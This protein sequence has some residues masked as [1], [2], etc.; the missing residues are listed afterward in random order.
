MKKVFKWILIIIAIIGVFIIISSLIIYKKN[1]SFIGEPDAEFVEYLNQNKKIL[2]SKAYLQK[3]LFDKNTYKSDIILLGEN[4]GYAVTQKID[5]NILIHLNKKI[6]LRNYI[7]EI[8]SIRAEL[9][10]NFLNKKEKDSILLKKIILAININIPQQSSREL[11][12]KWSEI[13]DYNQKLPDS[14]KLKILGV[15]K[16][17][18]KKTPISRDSAMI[19]NFKKFIKKK[20]IENEQ[21]YGYFGLFHVSQETI[22]NNTKSFAERLKSNNFKVKSIVC[23]N[24]DSEVYLPKNEKIP[25]TKSEKIS[26]L[27]MDGPI[28]LVK[29]INDLKKASTKENITLFNLNKKNSPYFNSKKL[30]TMKTN[31]INQNW[32]PEKDNL[33]TTDFFQYAILIRNSKANTPINE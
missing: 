9:L 26:F 16:T 14:L 6:G 5:K 24:I 13:Y 29:G 17:F 3:D 10:N 2:D 18:G 1:Q 32:S 12:D 11:F 21:F 33:K 30:I 22:K 25:T 27:N 28:V 4:H 15:D 7:A 8:D 20:K 19:M 23:L 31:F